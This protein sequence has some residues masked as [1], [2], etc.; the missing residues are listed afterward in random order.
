LRRLS[1]YLGGVEPGVSRWGVT[2]RELFAD[3][4]YDALIGLYVPPR[5]T[6]AWEWDFA[7]PDLFTREAGGCFTDLQ[8]NR[9]HYNKLD[10]RNYG[11]LLMVRDERIHGQV[12][13]AI[14]ALDIPTV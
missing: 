10:A 5:A 6:I 1:G 3:G 2:P 9:F 13:D 8:G 12:R 4:R 14:T 7:A 11:G